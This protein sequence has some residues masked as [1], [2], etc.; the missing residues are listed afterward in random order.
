MYLLS[1]IFYIELNSRT[2]TVLVVSTSTLPP[3]DG[4]IYLSAAL[5]TSSRTVYKCQQS[6]LL[7]RL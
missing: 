1:R 7:S 2:A 5:G 3:A 6:S 4:T